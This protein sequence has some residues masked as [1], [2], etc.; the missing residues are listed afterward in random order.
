MRTIACLL[1]VA[2]AAPVRV[3]SPRRQECYLSGSDAQVLMI[4][5]LPDGSIRPVPNCIWPKL[6]AL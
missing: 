3:E 1:L 2:C 6:A 5:D 4:D